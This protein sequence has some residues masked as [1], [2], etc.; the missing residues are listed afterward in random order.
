MLEFLR[1]NPYDVL[2]LGNGILG[3]SLAYQ[4]RKQEPRLKLAVVGPAARTGGATVTAGAMINVWAEVAAGQ[5]EN[6]ALADRVEL[7]MQ[8][9]P[10]W[11]PLCA[12]L[13]EFSDR[14]L[15]AAWGS[16]VI[17]NAL[18]SPHEVAAVDYILDA[19]RQRGIDH[20]VCA[21]GEVSWLKP[22]PRGQITR[23]I[24]V[25]DGRID[26]RLV[27]KAYEKCLAARDVA[28]IDGTAAR[29]ETGS[30]AARRPGGAGKRVTLSDGAEISAQ[31][32]VL[33]NGSFAQ[34][35]I[36]GAPSLKREIPRLLWGAGSALDV[37]FPAWIH[38][39]GGLDRSVF[40]MDAV[41][42]TVDRGGA[43]GV[44][45]IPY[46][47]GEY[48]LGASSGVWF[49]PENKPRVHAMHVLL[50][51]LVEEIHYAF[52]YATV[53]IRG[54]GFRPVTI[55][56]FPLLGESHIPGIWFANG[57]KRDGF[58]CS[59]YISRELARA[60]L[61]G[62]SG[63]P[64]RFQPARKL[65]SYK[66]RRQALDDGVAADLGGEA[67]HGLVL[68]PYA[69]PAYRE[70]KRA[71]A[72]KVYDKRGITDFGIHPE[73]L[74]LYDNDEFFAAIDHPREPVA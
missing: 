32:V 64:A 15:Q 8:A 56:T 28:V 20:R 7:T 25:P 19:M 58:T 26:P 24:K 70:A 42:R 40:D 5:F 51:S 12:E 66:N 65:I 52:F 38:K 18:G 35:L 6:P 59:P 62:P 33:A 50:R 4:L 54:P 36:D 73:V 9:M 55:D 11:D 43:R 29:L 63:L 30:A 48:Y 10:L 13:S 2:I 74:H 14:P 16:Y 44:H 49:E 47:G 23:I 39:Y 67:Q 71:K 53:S 17:N 72:E 68:P 27:L 22:E 1:G 21:P 41:V 34:A 60:I 37:S 69:G 57:T 61:G 46:G 45:L 31:H 3:L